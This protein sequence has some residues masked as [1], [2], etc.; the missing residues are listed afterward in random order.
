MQKEIIFKHFAE[1]DKETLIK[2]L[3]LTWEQLS[4]KNQRNTFENLY[5]ELTK[6]DLDAEEFFQ[7]VENFH[8]LSLAGHYYTPFDINSKNFMHIPD[9]TEEWFDEIG[10]F[11]DDACELVDKGEKEAVL[12]A[13]K[14]LMDLV[15]RMED[16]EEIIFA[17]EYGSWMINSKRDYE[18]IYQT[19]IGA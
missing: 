16:G 5:K 9:E 10:D 6:S 12:P 3:D 8:S 17:D 14:L 4:E 11:L 1:C 18:K 13:F 15:K 7:K 19:L 2:Y